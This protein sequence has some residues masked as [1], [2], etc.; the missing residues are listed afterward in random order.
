MSK[1]VSVI[2]QKGGVGKTTLTV[3]LAH[4]L[5]RM[6]KKLKVVIADADPQQSSYKWIERGRKN[7]IDGVGIKAVGADGEG[8][9]L[10]KELNAI[11]ADI[12]LI[13]L[14]PAIESLSLRAALYADVILVPIGA[15]ALDIEAARGAIDVCEEAMELD[16]TKSMLLIPSKVRAGT[17]AGKELRSLLKKWGT[18]SKATIGLRVHYSD[19]ATAGEGVGTYAKNSQAHKEMKSLAKEV[20][21]LLKI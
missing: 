18:V 1:I 10:K 17:T 13:D 16:D 6:K 4:E 3:H 7:D 14:P 20:L 12:I 21:G 15:S 19:A 9:K 11:D 2:Q 8:K 5:K